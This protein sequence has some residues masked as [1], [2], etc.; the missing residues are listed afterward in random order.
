MQSDPPT[1]KGKSE[2]L[3]ASSSS[4]SVSNLLQ[5]ML[6]DS[7]SCIRPHDIR[8]PW[9]VFGKDETFSLPKVLSAGFPSHFQEAPSLELA[10]EAT[11]CV[12]NHRVV[13]HDVALAMHSKRKLESFDDKIAL[14][15]QRF[16]L[17]LAH[18]YSGSSLGR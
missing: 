17:L 1:S 13:Y 9:E 18:E 2:N 4:R 15:S 7:S 6:S 10:T 16:E 5:G 11:T 14:L 8:M 12:E 3:P